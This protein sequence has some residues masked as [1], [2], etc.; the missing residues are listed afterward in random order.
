MQADYWDYV[1]YIFTVVEAYCI[2]PGMSFEIKAQYSTFK[3]K[4]VMTMYLLYSYIAKT[5]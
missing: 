1:V 3:L 4:M 5:Q 2:I